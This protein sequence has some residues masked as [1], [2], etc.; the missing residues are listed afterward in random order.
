MFANKYDNAGCIRNI[1]VSD[2][3][4][5]IYMRISDQDNGKDE[6][7]SITYQRTMIKN[8]V[9]SLE[10][11]AHAQVIEYVDDGVSGSHT[12]RNAYQRLIADIES[13]IVNCII[14]KDLSR[15]GRNLI[16]VDDLLMNYLVIH[17]VRFIALGNNYDSLK[18][19]LFNLE[20]ALINLSNQYYNQDIA[21]KSMSIRVMKMKRGEFLSCWALFG[22][23]K[24]TTERNKIIIDD[25]SANYVRMIF[26]L[27]ADGNRAPKIAKILN[28][29][30]IPTPGE[31]K[32]RKGIKGGWRFADP[33][34]SFWC[35]A[36]V[37]KILND[38]RYTGSAVHKATKVKY[39]GTKLCLKRPKNEWIIVPNAH[40][41]IIAQTEYDRVHEALRRS[42]WSDK[43]VD[44]IFYGK[45]KCSVCNRTLSRLNPKNPYFKCRSKHYTDHYD[46][47]DC[48]ITQEK[49]EEIVLE[50]IK[51]KVAISIEHEEMK[52]TALRQNSTS[53]TEME[54]KL[55]LEN[56]AVRLLEESITKNI[57]A[58]ISEQITQE[59]FLQ[60][61]ELVNKTIM[62]KRLVIEN[63]NEQ[64]RIITEGKEAVEEKLAGLRPLIDI[65][66]L[67]REL[68]DLL[69]EKVLVHGE[70]DVEIVWIV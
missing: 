28:A 39:P 54:R 15:I 1:S 10:E 65:E 62:Q 42:R 69:I 8:Y 32:K 21:H 13:G 14:V 20:L 49:I 67:D 41:A 55:Q 23:K 33:G 70:K 27:A 11:F 18:N 45:I 46:C 26:S 24:S 29:Q 16:E 59:V 53:K 31:Y 61:K 22:Y 48:L 68:V 7:N 43:P 36:K 52:L 37:G 40:E 25:E 66:K 60:K 30:E 51:V 2:Y 44:H 47:P 6:S 38:I 63:L 3:V 58:L 9:T 17:K 19:P 64:L 34:Y 35:N 4:I 57:T 56:N 50:S 5:A 12:K